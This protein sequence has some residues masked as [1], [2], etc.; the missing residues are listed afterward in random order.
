MTVNIANTVFGEYKR[1]AQL[2]RDALVNSGH[3][4]PLNQLIDLLINVELARV[5]SEEIAR[6]FMALLRVQESRVPN[7]SARE[8][9]LPSTGENGEIQ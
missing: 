4:L 1:A 8:E 2:I 6:Q 3:E 9:F 7:D 5:P